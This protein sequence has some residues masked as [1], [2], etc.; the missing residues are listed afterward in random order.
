MKSLIN[1]ADDDLSPSL[2]REIKPYKRT[3]S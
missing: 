1:V 2:E 3:S